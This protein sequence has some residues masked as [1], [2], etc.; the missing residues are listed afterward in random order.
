MESEVT[1]IGRSA[2]RTR[3]IGE[4]PLCLPFWLAAGASSVVRLAVDY[5]RPVSNG[6][7]GDGD[8]LHSAHQGS[9][10][11]RNL[12]WNV[13]VREKDDE[14]CGT[15]QSRWSAL[16]RSIASAS[17]AGK[18]SDAHA[19][20]DSGPAPVEEVSLHLF[21][22]FRSFPLRLLLPLTSWSAAAAAADSSVC[23]C[24]FRGLL[25]ASDRKMTRIIRT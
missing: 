23:C 21:S 5:R 12:R 25:L 6:F 13:F 22:G 7:Y 10:F 18:A 4:D 17:A 8:C 11:V 19:T 24:W 1:S 14:T 9:P 3:G 20:A 2:S 16:L 15:M